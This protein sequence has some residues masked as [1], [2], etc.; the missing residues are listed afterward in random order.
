MVK[1]TKQIS[2]RK[3]YFRDGY[4]SIHDTTYRNGKLSSEQLIDYTKSKKEAIEIKKKYKKK[5]YG[6]KYTSR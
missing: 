6:L 5:V 3:N 1:I 4:Y 2:I